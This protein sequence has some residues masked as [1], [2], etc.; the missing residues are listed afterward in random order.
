MRP[1][2]HRPIYGLIFNRQRELIEKYCFGE[3][4]KIILGAIFDPLLGEVGV[5]RTAEC[6]YMEKQMD[7]PFGTVMGEPVYIR[8][9]KS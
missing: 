6:P 8:K 9:L 5:C 3:C 2:V 4:K 1:L 7:E